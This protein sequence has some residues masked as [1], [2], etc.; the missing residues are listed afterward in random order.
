MTGR[1]VLAGLCG[2]IA[3][4]AVAGCTGGIPNASGGTGGKTGAGHKHGPVA[5]PA[6]QITPA[7]GAKA[8]RPNVPIHIYA[9]SGHLVSV[10]VHGGGQTVV[11]QMN[12]NLTEWTS[13]WA[14]TPGAKYVI[15]ATAGNSAGKTVTTMAKFTT[16]HV[17]QTFS[18]ALD[19]TLAGNQGHPYG[20]GL[21]IILNF[22]EPVKNKAAVAK[23][24]EVTAQKPVPGAWHWM[25]DEQV[26]YRVDG[27]WP[28]HQTVMLHAHLSG[29]KV[30]PGVY[31]TKDLTYKFKIGKAQ[32]SYVNLK[33]DHMKVF[34]DGKL[35][36]AYGVSGGDGSALVYTTPSGT[37]VTMD[38]NLVVTMTNPNVP[39]G[40]PGWY[41][42]QVPLAVRLT[43]SGI[44]LHQTPGA[45]WCIGVQ[46]C[47][48]G[49]IR[50]LAADAQWYY[51][52][53]QTADVVHVA[54]TD[55]KMIFGDGWTFYQMSW[56]RWSKGAT[57][58]YASYPVY[59]ARPVG[60]LSPKV[61]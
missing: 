1:G 56:S 17:T 6:V 12:P 50:Q 24:L 38:K 4:T 53:N 52:H 22:T 59:T 9:L 51:D 7:A 41:S 32:V 44:Y 21:P 57:I 25:S 13:L 18:A 10:V 19:W 61:Q 2:V 34:I 20:I 29:V 47:S 5:A 46:N 8:V 40:A 55:R 36:K 42:E 60:S 45:E 28:P 31:G 15:Q 49:C 16:L 26:V 11:G 43:N 54:G 37:A 39:K 33:T 3:V 23:A 48:H 27:Y 30:A 58:N 35:A 14:L